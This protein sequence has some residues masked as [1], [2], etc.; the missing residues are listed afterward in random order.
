MVLSVG[1]LL[2]APELLWSEWSGLHLRMCAVVEGGMPASEYRGL[3][4]E[5]TGYCLPWSLEEPSLR[6]VETGE[7]CSG[8]SIQFTARSCAGPPRSLT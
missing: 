5:G 4:A 7:L 6:P 2:S 8:I 1:P 3:L